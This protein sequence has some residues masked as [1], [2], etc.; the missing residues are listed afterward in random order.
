MRMS[1]QWGVPKANELSSL[2]R[3]EHRHR[4]KVPV[5]RLSERGFESRRD[6]QQKSPP[7]AGGLFCWRSSVDSDTRR[8]VFCLFTPCLIYLPI[9][10]LNRTNLS[11]AA[12]TPG[13][14]KTMIRVA[15]IA[16]R[17]MVRQISPIAG[18]ANTKPRMPA[19]TIIMDAEVR[20]VCRD[21]V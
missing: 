7:L 1:P 20:M 12:R 5:R 19:A 8:L 10:F 18:F 14:I 17:E 11:R 2:A 9:L 13:R 15:E 16:P 3:N 4:S 21:P 6:H